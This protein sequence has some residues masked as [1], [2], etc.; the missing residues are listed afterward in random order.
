MQFDINKRA[1]MERD[2]LLLGTVVRMIALVTTTSELAA[3]QGSI[4]KAQIDLFQA[5]VWR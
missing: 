2:E 5:A 3:V 1:A 4:T